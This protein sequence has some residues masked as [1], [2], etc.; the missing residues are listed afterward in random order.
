[1]EV[2]PEELRAVLEQYPDGIILNTLIHTYFI[3]RV[4]TKNFQV[5]MR[6]LYSIAATHG[7]GR[8]VLKEPEGQGGVTEAGTDLDVS[9]SPNNNKS[10]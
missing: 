5:F 3:T 4:N 6:M 2:T 8:V 7:D 1:M 10:N 9:A